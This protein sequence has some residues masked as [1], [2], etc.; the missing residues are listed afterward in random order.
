MAPLLLDLPTDILYLIMSDLC[1]HCDHLSAD[2][3]PDFNTVLSRTNKVSLSH[4]CQTS[5]RLCGIAQPFLYHCFYI[6]TTGTLR[7]KQVRAKVPI[8]LRT[9]C[10]EPGLAQALRAMSL[11]IPGGWKDHYP[12]VSSTREAMRQAN[13]WNGF[14]GTA[15]LPVL[16]IRT[17]LIKLSPNLEYMEL[18]ARSGHKFD[19]W[20]AMPNALPRIKIL[21]LIAPHN[22]INHMHD[23]ANVF[24]VMPNLKA[25]R[26]PSTSLLCNHNF[27]S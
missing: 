15:W 22:R 20:C 4:L 24:H 9:V 25:V 8:F 17:R 3:F 7:A 21:E 2:T 19:N 23:L 14:R 27:F 12:I 18:E 13:I 5:K 6:N 1:I 26:A 16:E 11:V 10:L